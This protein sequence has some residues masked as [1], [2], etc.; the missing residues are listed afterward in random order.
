M[1][2]LGPTTIPHRW[3]GFHLARSVFFLVL[4]ALTKVQYVATIEV[5]VEILTRR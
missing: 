5:T 3:E 4:Y 1:P 2:T